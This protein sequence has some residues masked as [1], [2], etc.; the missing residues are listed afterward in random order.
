MEELIKYYELADKYIHW[1][2]LILVGTFMFYVIL[3][4]TLLTGFHKKSHSFI[5]HYSRFLAVIPFWVLFSYQS[6]LIAFPKAEDIYLNK[7]DSQE[8]IL[9]NNTDE[10]ASFSFFAKRKDS[11]TWDP[12]LEGDG[13]VSTHY[14]EIEPQNRK[15]ADLFLDTAV[16]SSYLVELHN[17]DSNLDFGVKLKSNFVPKKIFVKDIQDEI[18]LDLDLNFLPL[19]KKA[20]YFLLA[21]FFLWY[22]YP[23]ILQKRKRRRFILLGGLLTLYCIFNLLNIARSVFLKDIIGI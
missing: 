17:G 22:H 16:Y 13:W 4:L 15:T 5:E 2:H 10:T 6:V 21:I 20:L 14:F 8:L 18:M 19:I 23:L 1:E 7:V 11:G 12:V 9:I 3:W